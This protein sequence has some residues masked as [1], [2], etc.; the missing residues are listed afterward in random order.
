MMDEIIWEVWLDGCLIDEGVA[1]CES[2]AWD[3]ADQAIDDDREGTHYFHSDYD[4]KIKEN[5]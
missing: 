1:E 3:M 5:F 4:I 2:E